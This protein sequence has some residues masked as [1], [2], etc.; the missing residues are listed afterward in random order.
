VSSRSAGATQRNPV[1]KNK[2]TKNNPPKTTATTTKKKSQ[3]PE[4]YHKLEANLVSV[5]GQ[6]KLHR[7]KITRVLLV[8]SSETARKI[9]PC[10]ALKCVSILSTQ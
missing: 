7:E 6:L 10:I 4:T 8:L 2:Q 9:K 3:V 5:P 1:S